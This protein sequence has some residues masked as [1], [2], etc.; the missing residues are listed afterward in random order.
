PGGTGVRLS[1]IR[2]GTQI[3]HGVVIFLVSGIDEGNKTVTYCRTR[4]DFIG[5]A[6]V[7]EDR[8]STLVLRQP[9]AV[10]KAP[11]IRIISTC[12]VT[13]NSRFVRDPSKVI[14]DPGGKTSKEYISAGLHIIRKNGQSRST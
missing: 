8:M 9:Y 10:V 5:K 6:Q 7:I 11:V 1:K 14:D 3:P 13:C 2:N 4:E 12:T